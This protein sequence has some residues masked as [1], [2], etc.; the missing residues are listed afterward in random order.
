MATIS[1]G[2]METISGRVPD[3]LY[4]WFAQLQVEGA[5]TNSDKLRVLL[6]QLKRQHEGSLD[7]VSAQSWFRDVTTPLR[8]CLATIER[9]EGSHS[10]V[11]STLVE[12]LSALAAARV[13]AHP[14]SRAEAVAFEDLLVRRAFRVT[15]ALLRQ[16]V[17]PQAAALD[18]GVVRKHCAQCITLAKLVH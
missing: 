18:P 7:L 1:G 11:V 8:R 13:S 2:T 4:R 10:E 15:E 5:V 14:R 9:D 6:A 3:D 16:A 12:H 17:T